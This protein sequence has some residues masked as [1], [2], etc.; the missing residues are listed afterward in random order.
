MEKLPPLQSIEQIET[1]KVLKK[2]TSTH[3]ALAE[4]KG[5][6][7]TIPNERILIDTLA[8]QEAKDSSEIENI[9]TTH[10]ELYRSTINFKEFPS[11]QAKEVHRYSEALKIGFDDVKNSGI[12][13]LKLILKIQEII[14]G[15]NAG[16]RKL[17]GTVLKNDLTGEVVYTPPQDYDTIL[18]LLGNFEKII[19]DQ[20]HF[21]VDPLVKMAIFHHQ[22][23]S[24]HP[25]YDG[26]GRTGRIVNIL[27]L[28]KEKLLNLPILYLSRYIIKN[29]NQYYSLLQ[30][31]RQQSDWEK[32]V[33]YILDAVEKTSIETV[34]T[35][36]G[37]KSLML[38]VKKK[39]RSEEPKIYSQDLIN[40]LFRHPY[41]KIRLLQDDL[42]VTRIT[43][44]KYLETLTEIGILNKI[45]VGRSNYY[46][47]H[48]LFDL[49]ST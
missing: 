5:V 45:K 27:Y 25:F 17:P 9:I 43:A 40:N 33:L 10:D 23:E 12:I 44:T 37:M 14:E 36:K 20:L 39:I 32:W 46:I 19:N 4:L 42:R 49:L 34:A 38:S 24:I 11:A 8:L 15:N 7:G 26:N 1:R 35:I 47:N 29:R 21:D 22:F 30:E 6:A 13:S 28:I 31:T 48:Q 16:V 2:L 18:D 3:A 41:T